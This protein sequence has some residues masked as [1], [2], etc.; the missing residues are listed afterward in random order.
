MGT[1]ALFLAA[2]TK[3]DTGGWGF[4]TARLPRRGEDQLDVVNDEEMLSTQ[5]Q[6]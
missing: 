5:R 1:N 6:T 4:T 2:T 3:I